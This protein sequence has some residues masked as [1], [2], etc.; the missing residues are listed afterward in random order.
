MEDS[1]NIAYR[2]PDIVFGSKTGPYSEQDAMLIYSGYK[3]DCSRFDT[4]PRSVQRVFLG[5]AMRIAEHLYHIYERAI[6]ARETFLLI[7]M[8]TAIGPGK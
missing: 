7:G 5:S 4:L 6:T 3:D 8:N 1:G 2:T